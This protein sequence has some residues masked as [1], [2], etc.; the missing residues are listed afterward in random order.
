MTVYYENSN[1]YPQTEYFRRREAALTMARSFDLSFV[2]AP[3]EPPLWYKAVRGMQKEKENGRRCL[4]CINFR[5]DRTFLYAKKNGFNWLATTLSV[6]RRKNT[7]LI[8]DLGRRLAQK[9]GLEFLGKDW[10]KNNGEI[11]SQQR[12]REAGIY[13]Q[14]YCGCVY[15]KFK[16]LK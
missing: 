13:R 6:S 9:H 8:N 2:E 12:A 1:I 11:I 7:V 10:K 3:Y 14:N 5:L 4:V 15:S 16:D